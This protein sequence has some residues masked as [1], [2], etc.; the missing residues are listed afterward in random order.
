VVPQRF[1]CPT[2]GSAVPVPAAGDTSAVCAGCSTALPVERGIVVLTPPAS[3][4]DYPQ[5]LVQLVTAV[6]DRHFWFAARNDVIVSTLRRVPGDLVNKCALDIG[7]GRGFVAAALERAGLIV[8][9]LDMHLSALTRARTRMRGLVLASSATTLPFFDDFNLAA[10]FDVIEHVDDDVAVLEQA[11]Q[12]LL[13]GGHVVVTV[14]A[15]PNLWTAYDEVIGHKRRYDRATL[16][17]ALERAHFTLRYVSYFNSAVVLAGMRQRRS[18]N[19]AAD[20]TAIVQ[21]ALKVPPEPLNTLLRWSVMA[22]GPLRRFSWLRGGSLI[23]VAQRR[24]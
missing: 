12:V 4:R 7:C 11:R 15:G 13:P 19:L 18:A 5:D 10:L 20:R 3:D 1:R 24:E 6:E 2:C 17:A 23:A 9:G 21:R 22:E 14:P 8:S 16:V